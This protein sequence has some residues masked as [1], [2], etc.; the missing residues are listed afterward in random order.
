MSDREI[1]DALAA[2]LSVL[3]IRYKNHVHRRTRN[4]PDVDAIIAAERALRAAKGEK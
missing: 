2:A 3:L 1:I 4:Q